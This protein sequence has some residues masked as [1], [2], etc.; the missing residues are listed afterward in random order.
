MSASTIEHYR[1]KIDCEN[2]EKHYQNST[3]QM[4]SQLMSRKMRALLKVLLLI[5]ELYLPCF[6]RE[7]PTVCINYL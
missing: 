1:K 6:I 5:I 2:Q 3:T 7:P 4:M